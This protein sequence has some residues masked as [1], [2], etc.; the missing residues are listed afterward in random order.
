[1]RQKLIIRFKKK[2]FN[3]ERIIDDLFKQFINLVKN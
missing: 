2:R 1:M 3:F